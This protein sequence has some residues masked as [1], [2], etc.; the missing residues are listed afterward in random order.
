M[1]GPT[2]SCAARRQ[3]AQ[4]RGSRVLALGGAL[5]RASRARRAR[6]ETRT[7]PT[8]M[9]RV[10]SYE[11]ERVHS[12]SRMLKTPPAA[13]SHR[14]DP[15]RTELSMFRPKTRRLTTRRRAQTWR[16]LFVAPCASLQPCPRNGASWRD[17]A[18]RV[19][20]LN[21]WPSCGSTNPLCR[22]CGPIVY[23]YMQAAGLVNDHTTD[24]FLCALRYE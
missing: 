10:W 17:G 18:G 6:F 9:D 11:A 19:R 8:C 4:R 12:Y 5:A 2:G 21:F 13:F 16:S 14:S 3:M 24:C 20:S 23:A 22:A 15:Q 7:S 1:G